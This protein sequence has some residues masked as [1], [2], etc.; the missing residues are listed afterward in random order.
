MRL[1]GVTKTFGGVR[2]LRGVDFDLRPGE[3]HALLGENGAGKS[4][5]IKIIAGAH[6]QDAGTI[7]YLG[8]PLVDNSPAKARRLG[9]NVIYQ[10]P[11]LFADLTVAENIGLRDEPP[12]VFRRIRW[13]HRR[14]RAAE[15][16]ARVGSAIDPE[17]EVRSLTMPQQ[18]LV[19]IA[20]ALGT[21]AKVL[22]L[23]EPTASLGE[24]DAQNLF[25]V[26]AQL[27]AEGVGI[28]Y[29]SH[30]LDEVVQIADRVTVLR[31]GAYVTTRDAAGI[32]PAEMIRLMVGRSVDAV[33][34]KVDAN[35]G[36]V[37]LRRG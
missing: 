31:D 8:R 23:D 24:Q 34:H 13:G 20:A 29:I 1:S 7:E 22:V 18:Q 27:R 11:A 12:G 30:R 37:V 28:V 2:A 16:L 15:L 3:V 10:Q 5:M 33:F 9:I 36:D 17:A 32:T 21:G 26:I 6:A 14:K 25:R 19:E 35:I 4:T